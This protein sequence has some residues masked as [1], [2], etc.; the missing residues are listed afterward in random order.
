MIT[1]FLLMLIAIGGRK[2]LNSVI[3]LIVTGLLIYYVLLP[4]IL[5]GHNPIWVSLLVSVL[6]TVI[7]F[8]LISG[9]N[10]KTYSALIGTVGGLLV[11]GVFAY[12]IGS[13]SSLTGLS[14]EDA[15]LLAYL[16]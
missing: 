12:A 9:N 3:S 2:G 6:S 7:T 11:G 14:S 16:P 4:L 15:Q 1:A 8:L 10:R 5:G 13:M